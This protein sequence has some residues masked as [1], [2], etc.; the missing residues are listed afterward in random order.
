MHTSQTARSKRG[1][2]YI[3]FVE[4]D[5]LRESVKRL[6]ERGIMAQMPGGAFK[7]QVTMRLQSYLAELPFIVDE[8]SELFLVL[9]NLLITGK[10]AR[11]PDDL[12]KVFLTIVA[13]SNAEMMEKKDLEFLK[14]KT[15]I[16]EI[17]TLERTLLELE[18][19]GYLKL[20]MSAEEE[21]P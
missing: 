5:P 11:M 9:Y 4:G 7:R 13:Y 8:V 10:L 6:I 15:G 17:A 18:R 16:K 12:F 3:P 1:C 19:K 2:E 14:E 21:Q 20:A